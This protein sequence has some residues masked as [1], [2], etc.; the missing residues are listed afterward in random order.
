MKIEK[1]EFDVILEGK[2][3]TYDIGGEAGTSEMAD[4]IVEA[5]R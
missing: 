2:N 5:M 1:A 4:A 3:V